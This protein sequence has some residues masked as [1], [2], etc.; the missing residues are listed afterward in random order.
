MLV[1]PKRKEDIKMENI[2]T[3]KDLCKNFKK[4]KAND[5]ISITVRKNSIYG[6]PYVIG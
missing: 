1:L 4:Q 6:L 2:L 5:N 3:T